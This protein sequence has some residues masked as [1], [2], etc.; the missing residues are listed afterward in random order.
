[1]R[2]VCVLVVRGNSKFLRHWPPSLDGKTLDAQSAA[3]LGT[4]ARSLAHHLE[5]L[6][7]DTFTE[8]QSALMK[9]LMGLIERGVAPTECWSELAGAL[10]ELASRGLFR[11]ALLYVSRRSEPSTFTCK[12]SVPGTRLQPPALHAADSKHLRGLIKR[13]NVYD[14]RLLPC[15]DV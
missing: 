7:D 3:L 9:G 13:R 11:S 4:I 2:S 1:M 8:M 14:M 10:G 6:D 12:V 15:V 5:T